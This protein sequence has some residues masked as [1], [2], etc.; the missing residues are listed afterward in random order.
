MTKS[1]SR[2]LSEVL[3]LIIPQVIR[4]QHFSGNLK[5]V[6]ACRLTRGMRVF[7]L[8]IPQ[9]IRI[10]FGEWEVAIAIRRTRRGVKLYKDIEQLEIILVIDN[11]INNDM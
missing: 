4:I 9:V 8:I 3:F 2:K 1:P 7:V 11:Y 5:V 10:Y 6:V